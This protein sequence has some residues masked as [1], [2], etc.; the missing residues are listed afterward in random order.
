M[1]RI[2]SSL[3]FPFPTPA[4]E[5]TYKDTDAMYL[6]VLGTHRSPL[7][8]EQLTVPLLLGLYVLLFS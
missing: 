1:T 7:I 3:P 6:Y 2:L 8:K 4:K 5:D